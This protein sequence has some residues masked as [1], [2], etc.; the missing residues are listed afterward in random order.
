MLSYKY[1]LVSSASWFKSGLPCVTAGCM[2]GS[3]KCKV[4]MFLSFFERIFSFP[5]AIWFKRK[6]R[7]REQPSTERLSYHSTKPFSHSPQHCCWRQDLFPALLCLKK[8]VKSSL[9]GLRPV[10]TYDSHDQKQGP[11]TAVVFNACIHL[12]VEVPCLYD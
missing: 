10:I 8:N 12:W 9:I 2:Q 1:T 4:T 5:L 7:A 3:Y 6:M 11:L